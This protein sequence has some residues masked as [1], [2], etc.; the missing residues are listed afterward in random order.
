[1]QHATFLAN[2]AHRDTHREY[3]VG[4]WAQVYTYIPM[5]SLVRFVTFQYH[6][7]C[8]I[9]WLFQTKAYYELSTNQCWAGSRG[10][11]FL[12]PLWVTMLDNAYL[13]FLKGCFHYFSPHIQMLVFQG[14]TS[15]FYKL[16]LV[17]S[18]RLFSVCKQQNSG[19]KCVGI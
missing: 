3:L 19:L 13:V 18:Q 9:C 7:F 8:S 2:T 15:T 4:I 5:C 1:M 12:I 16:K 17:L 11:H 6:Y 14:D 10:Q